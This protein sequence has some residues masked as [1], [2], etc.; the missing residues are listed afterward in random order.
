MTETAQ[1]DWAAYL[2][3]L[4]SD[5]REFAQAIIVAAQLGIAD[6]LGGG[7]QSTTELAQRTG[8]HA[9]SLYR[10]LQY[11]ASRG[12][13]A[14]DADGRFSLTTRAGP[15][16]SDDPCSIQAAVRWNGSDAYQ[17]TWTN[18]AYSVATGQSAFEHVHGKPVFDHFAENPELA[19]A[20]N[21]VMTA[22]SVDEGPAVV[23]AYDFSRFRTIVDVG[24]GHGALLALIL[25]R[26]PDVTGVLFDAPTVVASASGAIDRHITV[27]RAETVAGDFF[28]AVPAN[29][30]A[31][32]LKFILHDWSDK[33]AL[34]I[35]TNCRAAMP[36]HG[37]VLIIEMIVPEGN[38][39]SPAK[40]LD[41][42]MLL[43]TRGRE[44]TE[45]EYAAL[46]NQAGLRLVATTPTAS[47]FSIIEAVAT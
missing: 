13:F 43:F 17:R 25:D 10:L 21:D 38:A 44:R 9:R 32:L 11:L 27:H 45:K 47:P 39:P 36:P 8:T 31:Y 6:L 30:D 26:N 14:E 35:L 16:R 7:P 4:I 5:D 3:R 37:T 46:L 1:S 33:Q 29:G 2:R 41:L 22:N 15:L 20:F 23:S 12:I 24:G 34:S 40:E 18:L 19:H 28:Q 42:T